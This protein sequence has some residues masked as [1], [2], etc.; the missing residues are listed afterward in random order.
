MPIRDFGIGM[1]GEKLGQSVEVDFRERGEHDLIAGRERHFGKHFGRFIGKDSSPL[2]A[3]AV[4]A[5][6]S[7]AIAKPAEAAFLRGRVALAIER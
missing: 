1:R 2:G 7:K 3:A 5:P 4:F 6:F